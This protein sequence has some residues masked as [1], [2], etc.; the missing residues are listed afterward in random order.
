MP[1]GDGLI[2][3]L[4]VRRARLGVKALRGL[5]AAARSAGNGIVELTRRGSLQIRGVSWATLPSLQADV[6]SL[7]LAEATPERERAPVLAVCPLGGLDPRSALLEPLADVLEPLLTAPELTYGLAE[8]FLVVLSGGSDLFDTLHADLRFEL[9]ASGRVRVRLAGTAL[10]ALDLG[11]C[12]STEVA[13]VM[14]TLLL[15][16]REIPGEQHRLRD[17]LE[18]EGATALRA[19]LTHFDFERATAPHGWR[20]APLGFHAG[21]EN[22]FGFELP[23]GSASAEDWTAIAEWAERFGRG[24]IRIL[25]QR[26]LLPGV[27]A[28]DRG[29]L[30]EL[31]QQRHFTVERAR[32]ALQLVACSGAPACRSARGET[33]RLALELAALL[34]GELSGDAT[35]HVSGCEKGCAWSGAADITLV[36]GSDGARL[37]FGVDV[38]DA[39]RQNPLS[40]D[41][42]RAELGARLR[43][44]EWQG[45]TSA[46][47]TP[48]A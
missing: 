3:R 38:A 9:E 43:A 47:R 25:P 29:R 14:R 39:A 8:K 31:A 6:R 17:L 1:S 27:T 45:R 46:D 18:Q 40:L 30:S 22:W 32:P 21:L 5:G 2:V 34:E 26:V 44:P 41:G 24:E 10:R 7:G 4:R 15:L 36:H 28:S 11:T 19:R 12:P 20:S 48:L 33:R 42:V 13:E 35:L 16:L 37:G 23:F